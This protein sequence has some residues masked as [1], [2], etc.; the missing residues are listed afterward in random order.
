MEF[1]NVPRVGKTP[2]AAIVTGA[3]ATVTFTLVVAGRCCR[4]VVDCAL[5]F[6]NFAEDGGGGGGGGG[7]SGGGGGGGGGRKH[8]SPVGKESRVKPESKTSLCSRMKGEKKKRILDH[9][10]SVFF[11]TYET[12]GNSV[13]V[14]SYKSCDT[15]RFHC[16]HLSYHSI[17][18]KKTCRIYNMLK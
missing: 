15:P 16:G 11:S 4:I 7:G 14:E 1:G 8:S 2:S 6:E 3:V 13:K 5:P 17:V 9:S 10:G 12:H 18:Q